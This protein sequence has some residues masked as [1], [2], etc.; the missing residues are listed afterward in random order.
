[1]EHSPADARVAGAR[2]R[3]FDSMSGR[4]QGGQ[5]ADKSTIPCVGFIP[6]EKQSVTDQSDP[7]QQ[8]L[9]TLDAVHQQQLE[10]LSQQRAAALASA[11]YWEELAQSASTGSAAEGGGLPQTGYQPAPSTVT[12]AHFKF[13]EDVLNA[14]HQFARTLVTGDAPQ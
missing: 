11:R 2:T 13:L 8:Q 4:R 1:M 12:A 10:Q 3:A 9:E 14:Q 7:R 5:R 6:K